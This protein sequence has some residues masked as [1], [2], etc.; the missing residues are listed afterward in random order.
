MLMSRVVK[1][2]LYS[3]VVADE[4]V[5]EGLLPLCVVG[6]PEITVPSRGGSYTEKSS[7]KQWRVRTN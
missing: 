3:A 1:V 7:V 2:R 5:C 6:Q 4:E